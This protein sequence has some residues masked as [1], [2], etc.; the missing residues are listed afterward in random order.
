M[1]LASTRNRALYG[2]LLG[3]FYLVLAL[4]VFYTARALYREARLSRLKTDF[5]SLV[6]HELRTPLTSI[7]MFIETLSLGRIQDQE[8]ARE[9]LSLLA[10]ETE[11]LSAMIDRVLDWARIESG[12][13]DYHL[14]SVSVDD[15]LAT[16]VEAFR[17]QRLEGA[18]R[19]RLEVEPALPKV[20]ADIEAVSGALLNLLN[21]A[22]KYS[23]AD[24]PIVLRA[25]RE[26]DEAAIEVIDQGV[27]ISARDRKKI[28]DRFYRVDN[29]LTRKTEGSGLGLSIAQRIAE[30]HGGVITVDSEPGKGSTFTLQLPF[31]KADNA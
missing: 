24:A 8:Q 15:V 9:V 13:K 21:N 5:V 26:G 25:R 22:Y 20:S 27:G 4:G 29:L 7:R 2:V 1:A 12:R 11:R 6:S 3:V 18:A 14:E 16:T 10:R 30:A 23:A 19:L 17:A 31:V 28:F